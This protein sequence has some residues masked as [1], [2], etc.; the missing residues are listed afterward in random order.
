MRRLGELEA[1]I[2][3]VMWDR[4]DPATVRDILEHLTPQRALAYT[5]VMTVM[6]NLHRKDLLSR[7]KAGRAWLYAATVSRAEYTAQLMREVLASAGD[8][9][10]ALTH[11]VA[12]MTD[13][14]SQELR[15]LLRRRGRGRQ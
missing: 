5:T 9:S 14:E 10:A 7:E 4:P 8:E 12:I 2:M 11:F 1:A 6:D 3:D 15:G 13:E